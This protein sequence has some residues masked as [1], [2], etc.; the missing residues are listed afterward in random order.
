MLTQS[1][2]GQVLVIRG[3]LPGV[4]DPNAPTELTVLVGG[5]EVVRRELNFGDF[6]VRGP[7]PGPAGAQR[8]AL[9]FDRTRKLPD[10]DGREVGARILEVV[11]QAA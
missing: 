11:F 7:A 1:A 5:T 9:R 3:H 10:P 4:G 8:V 2:P 6:E